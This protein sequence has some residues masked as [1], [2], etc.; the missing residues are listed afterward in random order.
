MYYYQKPNLIR[1]I[2]LLGLSVGATLSLIVLKPDQG[3]ISA[4]SIVAI[5]GYAVAAIYLFVT[6]VRYKE[7]RSRYLQQR[8]RRAEPDILTD[9]LLQLL[10]TLELDVS[11]RHTVRYNLGGDRKRLFVTKHKSWYL[12]R[13]STEEFGSYDVDTSSE[14]RIEK[15]WTYSIPRHEYGVALLQYETSEIVSR[16]PAKRSDAK[17]SIARQLMQHLFEPEE[18]KKVEAAAIDLHHLYQHIRHAT[19]A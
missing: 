6:I 3:V 7:L 2:A 15:A 14:T 16:P 18:F 17:R 19:T 5:L 8:M 10:D 11:G 12:C 13:L 4:L 9:E 1:D